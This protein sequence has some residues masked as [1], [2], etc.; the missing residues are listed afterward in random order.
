MLLLIAYQK[1][2]E[3]SCASL[4]FSRSDADVFLTVDSD[5]YIYPDALEELLKSF[6]DKDVYAA[7]GHLN[8]RNRDVN[9]LTILTDIRYDNAFGVERAGPV[10]NREYPSMFRY[11]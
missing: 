11:H 9:L 5:S 8:A 2:W 7:T 4:Y 10:C 6:N 1:T 3:T